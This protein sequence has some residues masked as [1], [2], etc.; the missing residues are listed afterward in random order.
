M[1]P[2][3]IFKM[4]I[5]PVCGS[6]AVIVAMLLSI[7]FTLY[8]FYLHEKYKHIP[9]PPLDSFYLGNL[10][11]LSRR[12]M[13]DGCAYAEVLHEWFLQ[14][15]SIF[16]FW[17]LHRPLVVVSDPNLAKQVCVQ[18]RAGKNDKIYRVLSAPYGQ[19]V[20]GKGLVTE[21]IIIFALFTLV[22]FGSLH[23]CIYAFIIYVI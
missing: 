5:L 17:A 11:Y 1:L 7:T 19:R 13:K 9:G 2:R 14:H 22:A 4:Y 15:G 3:T 16:V 10:P 12:R 6:I 20:F 18:L 21:V 8:L 23:S